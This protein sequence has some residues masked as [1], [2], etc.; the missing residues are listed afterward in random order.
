MKYFPLTFT[1]PFSRD[2]TEGIRQPKNINNHEQLF[3][4]WLF[5]LKY[6]KGI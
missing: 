4:H 6:R 5:G 3:L 2:H 1:N